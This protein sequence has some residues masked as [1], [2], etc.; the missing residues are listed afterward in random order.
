MATVNA[1]A[2]ARKD[3]DLAGA[4]RDFMAEARRRVDRGIDDAT[5]HAERALTK[6]A[7]EARAGKPTLVL[8]RAGRSYNAALERIRETTDDLRGIVGEAR[9][10]FYGIA[11]VGWVACL[12]PQWLRPGARPTQERASFVRGLA[13]H[14]YPLDAELRNACEALER[15]LEQAIALASTPGLTQDP[16]GVVEGW[17]QR[18]RASLRSLSERL[19]DD[20]WVAADRAAGRDCLRPELL[21]PD[22]FLDPS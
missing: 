21:E 10:R 12:D 8:I 5:A 3:A 1:A 22:P 9:E 13:L 6:V 2:L 4:V 15:S 16:G 17:D 19:I 14:G 20:S 7:R 11:Y 18:S